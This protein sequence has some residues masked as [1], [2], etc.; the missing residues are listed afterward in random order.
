MANTRERDPR[1]D[2][3]AP[4]S[5]PPN[6]PWARNGAQQNDGLGVH[7]AGASRTD[8]GRVGPD[9]RPATMAGELMIG[10][11]YYSNAGGTP[12]KR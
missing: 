10:L 4:V 9:G 7:S 2:G 1:V 8:G 6:W 11:G 12:F 5:L 3:A